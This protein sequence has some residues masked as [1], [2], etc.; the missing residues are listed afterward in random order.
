MSRKRK[1]E[2]GSGY[3]WMDTYG[4]LVTLILTFFVLLYAMS[5]MDAKKWETLASAFNTRAAE[6]EQQQNTSSGGGSSADS[7]SGSSSGT[8]TQVTDFSDLY[9][10]MAQT[11]EENNLGSTVQVS[12][13]DGYVFITF[14]NSV[15]FDGDSSVL[16]NEGKVVLDY[17]AEG[18]RYIPD[19]IGELRVMGHTAQT[20][21]DVQQ[22]QSAIIF[23]RQLS[24]D[25]AT[26]VLLYIQFKNVLD[27]SKLI[28]EG[29]GQYRPVVA[30][31]GTEATRIKNRRVEIYIVE[32]GAD[33]LSLG[34]IYDQ[35]N[36]TDST[37]K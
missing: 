9:E 2:E 23:D 18:M 35:I 6:A 17:V 36:A 31:D 28:A 7:S 20:W 27:P 34:E 37:G 21:E 4:D 14:Q 3:N 13:G 10:Y 16:K 30:H 12:D 11:V 15:F 24:V 8:I 5:S 26:Q 33:E 25:R 1:P 29:Y 22:I 32:K 19:Q